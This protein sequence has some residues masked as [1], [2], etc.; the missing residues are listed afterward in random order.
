MPQ[1]FA[2]RYVLDVSATRD[3]VRLALKQLSTVLPGFARVQLMSNHVNA[4]LRAG[5]EP[6]DPNGFK[7][8]IEASEPVDEGAVETALAHLPIVITRF[9]TLTVA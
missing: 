6:V 2:Y 1:E 9:R 4:I 7:I 3:V 5:R 8:R